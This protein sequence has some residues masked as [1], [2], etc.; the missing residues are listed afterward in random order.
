MENFILWNLSHNIKAQRLSFFATS[1]Q[2]KKIN[3]GTEDMLNEMIQDLKLSTLFYKNWKIKHFLTN[4]I[5]IHNL[6]NEIK[7]NYVEENQ[8]QGN[9]FN[10]ISIE[11]K[12]NQLIISLGC[13]N[14]GIA[15]F[16]KMDKWGKKMGLN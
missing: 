2:I 12:E 5:I 16:Q 6:L 7:S 15:P 11:Q 13:F 1:M 3:Q 14:D 10:K 9:D 4:Y 8:L